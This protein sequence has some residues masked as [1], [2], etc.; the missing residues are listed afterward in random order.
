MCI[1]DSYVTDIEVLR[2]HYAETLRAWR[3]HFDARVDQV[4]QIY[5][6]RFCRMWRF[7][8]VASELA[9]RHGG[10]VVFQ[11]QLAKRQDAVPLT[12]DYLMPADLSTKP[13]VR[14]AVP[15]QHL[16]ETRTDEPYHGPRLGRGTM[17]ARLE[18]SPRY[19]KGH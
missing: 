19:S 13:T 5:D 1:R 16:R 18:Q 4:R 10:Y 8:L 3:A 17:V 14:V 2:L 11:I 15:G 7:Y 6:E 9:F 12:R